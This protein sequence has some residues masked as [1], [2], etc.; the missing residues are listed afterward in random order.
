MPHTGGEH[1]RRVPVV[2]AHPFAC[3]ADLF[4]GDLQPDENWDLSKASSVRSSSPRYGIGS[5]MAVGSIR[6]LNLV[7]LGLSWNVANAVK[8]RYMYLLYCTC[9]YKYMPTFGHPELRWYKYAYKQSE[10]EPGEVN[11]PTH[12]PTYLSTYLPTIM[13]HRT[14]HRDMHFSPHLN[15][16]TFGSSF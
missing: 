5:T 16:S 2:S 3:I 10:Y 14:K 13:S 12:Q 4:I 15:G 9:M 11:I 1:L 7:L 8:T 6:L